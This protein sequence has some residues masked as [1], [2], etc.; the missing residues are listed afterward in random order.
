MEPLGSHSRSLT[1][2]L[3]FCSCLFYRRRSS[4]FL[5][6]C[7]LLFSPLLPSSSS[8]GQVS[9]PTTGTSTADDEEE[10]VF[11]PPPLQLLPPRER[12]QYL[13]VPSLQS[14]SPG[15]I[16]RQINSCV[17]FGYRRVSRAV[18]KTVVCTDSHAYISAQ[19]SSLSIKGEHLSI[20]CVFYLH[21]STRGNPLVPH[22]FMPV[23]VSI[24]ICSHPYIHVLCLWIDIYIQM[25]GSPSPPC[26]PWS[27]VR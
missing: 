17:W 6:S 12:F 23:E 10:A 15:E 1:L 27:V 7:S 16:D 26:L 5:S 9:M 22:V 19:S 21:R 2:C 14:A 8:T 3:S 25:E 11:E 20:L 24:D 4:L 13:P 18:D